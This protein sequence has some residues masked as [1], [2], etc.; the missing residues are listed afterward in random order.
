MPL[1]DKSLA[2]F[3]R[4]EI[5][6]GPNRRT[7]TTLSPFASLPS[8]VT[9]NGPISSTFSVSADIFAVPAWMLCLSVAPNGHQAGS[10][11]MCMSAPV[12]SWIY[13]PS[14]GVA[15]SSGHA[16]TVLIACMRSVTLRRSTP[17]SLLPPSLSPWSI[18]NSFCPRWTRAFEEFFA[19]SASNM[20]SSTP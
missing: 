2:Y 18:A 10:S 6:V 11:S 13:W 17:P 19:W 14:D 16:D 9:I 4:V 12:S 7:V 15:P 8:I 5:A 1:C 20:L 3:L